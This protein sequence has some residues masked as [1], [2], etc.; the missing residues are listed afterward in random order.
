MKVAF[1][2]AI[3]MLILLAL[4]ADTFAAPSSCKRA[5]EPGDLMSLWVNA[6][7]IYDPCAE[8]DYQMRGVM[9]CLKRGAI[10]RV[11]EPHP[12]LDI[13]SFCG[14]IRVIL[15]N[16]KVGWLSSWLLKPVRAK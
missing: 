8:G 15:P 12:T 13:V 7:A 3:A 14:K 5:P 2:L 11:A 1:V 10:V 9:G 6:C 16:G 4:I